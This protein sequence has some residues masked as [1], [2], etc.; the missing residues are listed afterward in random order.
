MKKIIGLLVGLTLL[1]GVATSTS[2]VLTAL[3]PNTLQFS[4]SLTLKD[5]H[6][7]KAA[8]LT[9]MVK[10]LNINVMS[11]GGSAFATISIKNTIQQLQK[12]RRV[13]II[14]VT[15]GM[16]FSGAAII[17]LLGD[18]RI[19]HAD[20]LLMFHGVQMWEKDK[21]GN[22]VKKPLKDYT[23][24]DKLVK[25]HLDGIMRSLLVQYLGKSATDVLLEDTYYTAQQALALGL[26]TK[27]IY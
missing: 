21:N 4:D 14:T 19:M 18:E 8:T 22:L 1:F 10:E 12:D 26:A 13:K 6:D 16:A 15:D 20:D 17:W 7:F 11:P 25:A 9:L 2:A 3:G 5:A 27:I 23:K 24:S